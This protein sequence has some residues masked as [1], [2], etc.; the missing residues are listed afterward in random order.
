ME[1]KL[2]VVDGGFP[3]PE[4]RRTDRFERVS[5]LQMVG[6]VQDAVPES[7]CPDGVEAFHAVGAHLAPQVHFRQLDETWWGI[8]F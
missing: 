5:P 6:P 8:L 3:R 7:D 2:V 4:C 1:N